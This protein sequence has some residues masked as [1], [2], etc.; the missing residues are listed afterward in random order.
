MEKAWFAANPDKGTWMNWPITGALTEPSALSEPFRKEFAKTLEDWSTDERG[1]EGRCLRPRS[2]SP[3]LATTPLL[4]AAASS[5]L[6]ASSS[7][8]VLAAPFA[9]A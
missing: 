2:S 6:S 5:H 9:P 8:V 1:F 7:L 3:H 4:R